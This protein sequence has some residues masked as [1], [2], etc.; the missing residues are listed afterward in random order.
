MRSFLASSAL[1]WFD[2]YHVDG[3]RVDGVASLLYRDYSRKAG[4]WI[5]NQFGGRENLEA[6]SLLQEI[7]S[8]VYKH[9]PDTQTIAEESTAWPSVSPTK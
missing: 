3:L 1:F 7:N 9:F 5:P 4:E 2:K 6:V 8:A